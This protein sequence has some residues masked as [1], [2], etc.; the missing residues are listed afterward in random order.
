MYHPSEKVL[1]GLEVHVGTPIA[2]CQELN[3]KLLADTSADGGYPKQILDDLIY[4]YEEPNSMTRWDSPLFTVPYDDEAPPCDDIWEAIIGSEG[5]AKI[6]K[7][8]QA[9]VMVC[10]T[11]NKYTRKGK[12]Q[13]IPILHHQQSITQQFIG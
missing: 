1:I 10:Q 5:K 11:S 2:K 13:R 8:N 12:N 4:R 3:A 7:P 9:T 6:V